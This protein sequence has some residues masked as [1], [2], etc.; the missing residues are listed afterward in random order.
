ML[1]TS[2]R[3]ELRAILHVFPTAGTPTW[4]KSD[5]KAVVD[6]VNSILNQEDIDTAELT[7]SD[8]WQLLLILSTGQRG[9]F[10]SHLDPK[11][12]RRG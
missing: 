3:G 6:M 7:D 9:L 4:I 1:H 8:L 12:L 2:Y 5:C 11:S 10:P